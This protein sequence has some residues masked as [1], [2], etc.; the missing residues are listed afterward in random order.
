[1]L[2][3]MLLYV[4][5]L[6]DWKN[7]KNVRLDNCERDCM[8]VWFY[9]YHQI[10]NFLNFC[11]SNTSLKNVIFIKI[12]DG[13]KVPNHGLGHFMY[14]YNIAQKCLS[15]WISGH[16]EIRIS[17]PAFPPLVKIRTPPPGIVLYAT[18]CEKPI[19]RNFSIKYCRC[20]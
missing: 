15:A 12:A 19:W 11:L 7:W 3:I 17:G 2:I 14:C 16:R 6:E 1:M 5:R 9:S 10:Y 4:V 18:I 13:A 20:E 8:K